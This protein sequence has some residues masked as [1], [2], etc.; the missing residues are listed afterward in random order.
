MYAVAGVS[1]N[2]G[3][4][5][6]NE[7]LSRGEKVRVL[8]RDAAKGAEWQKKGAE[9]AVARLEDAA[10]LAAALKGVDGV[11]LLIPPAPGAADVLADRQKLIEAMAQAVQQSG[12][13]HVVL[14]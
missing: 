1:G 13:P 12:V 10:S 11:Y 9:V 4:V 6:A 3:S 2:T 8:V 5:V 14:L 7:L